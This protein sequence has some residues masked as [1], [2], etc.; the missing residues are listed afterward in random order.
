[1]KRLN[2]VLSSSCIFKN[3]DRLMGM[4]I[5][6]ANFKRKHV[7]LWLTG[8]GIKIGGREGLKEGRV[9]RNGWGRQTAGKCVKTSTASHGYSDFINWYYIGTSVPHHLSDAPDSSIAS[10]SAPSSTSLEY[11]VASPKAAAHKC[12][13]L[14]LFLMLNIDAQLNQPLKLRAWIHLLPLQLVCPVSVSHS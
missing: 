11:L 9:R 7:H 14:R 1:M 4:K 10:S 3:R 13:R 8:D 12:L 6:W 5:I 2:R